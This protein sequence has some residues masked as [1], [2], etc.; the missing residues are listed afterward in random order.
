MGRGLERRFIFKSRGDKYDF[1][2]RLGKSLERANAKCLAWALMSDHYH[3]LVQASDQTLSRMMASV[4][5]GYAGNY[6]R[7]HNRCGYVFQ[8]RY[9]SIL[10]D[11]DA[12]LLELIRYIHL[13]PVRAGMISNQNELARYPWS[14]HAGILNC[15][16]Q[17]WH[18]IDA[19]LSHFGASRRRSISAY[20]RFI[21]AGWASKQNIDLSGGGLVRSH[22]GWQGIERLRK[23]HTSC[24][25]DERILGSSRFVESALHQD[26]LATETR[27]KLYQQ[28]WNL[29]EV[30]RW[31]CKLTGISENQLGHKA[32]GGNLSQAKAI[33]CYLGYSELGLTLREIADYLHITQPSVSA[34]VTKGEAICRQKSISLETANR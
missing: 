16:K 11:R 31:A 22:G 23:E 19:V 25:G 6:N 14:G 12:Y 32:R 13:N 17:D 15:H 2:A 21:H 4:L 27:T 24:I 20:L 26:E 8:N 3:L 7:R 33:L 29:S 9:K 34:W 28:G 1:L 18:S 10:V 30:S 5:G